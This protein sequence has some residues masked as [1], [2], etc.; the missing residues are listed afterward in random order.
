MIKIEKVSKFYK[1]NKSIKVVFNRISLEINAGDFFVLVGPNGSG[2]TTLLKLIHQTVHADNGQIILNDEICQDEISFVS[3]SYR[4]FFLNLTLLDNLKFFS[5]LYEK[6]INDVD[7]VI[8]SYLS[9]LDLISKKND[10]VSILSSG[11]IK[12]LSMIRSLLSEPK[13]LLLD[14][15]TSSLDAATKIKIVDYI[16]K[17]NREKNIAIIWA[18]HHPDEISADKAISLKIKDHSLIKN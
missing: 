8:D 5:A 6:K 3:Q 15:V 2:K 7:E 17:L 18:T 13:I 1:S 9:S 16:Y 10:F 12:K 14:E 4:S 11:E